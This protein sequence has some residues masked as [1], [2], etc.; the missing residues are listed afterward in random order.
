CSRRGKNLYDGYYG[1]P[2]YALDYW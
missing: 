2:Y 1:P